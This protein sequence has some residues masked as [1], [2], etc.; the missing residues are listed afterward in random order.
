MSDEKEPRPQQPAEREPVGRDTTDTEEATAQELA[1]AKRDPIRKI[2]LIV[3]S[4]CLVIFI[5]YIAA[6]R[7]TPYTDQARIQSLSVKAAIARV[8]VARAQLDSAQRNFNRTQLILGDNPGALS[9]ADRDRAETGL[10]QAVER[11]ASSEADLE[12][13]QEQLGVQGPENPELRAAIAALE[14]AQLNL[15]FSTLRAPSHGVIESFRVD[16]GHYA[17]AGQPLA[18]FISSHDIWIQADM[19]ENNISNV[20]AGDDVEF[21][22]DVAPGRIFKGTVRS[23]GYGVSTGTKTTPG[24]LPTITSAEGWL[25]D[26]QRFPL[27]IGLNQGEADDLRRVGGQADVVVYTASSNPLLNAIAWIQIRLRSWISYVR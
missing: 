8:G 21:S 17:Q 23:V 25:R 18:T 22:L 24:D 14:Q 4:V 1:A 9:Q 6:D 27:I 10:A 15:E 26:P 19:R 3:L 20:K 12:K 13:A 7:L 5:W 2:T 11:L 16:L